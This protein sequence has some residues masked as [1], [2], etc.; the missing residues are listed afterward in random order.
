MST[1]H[2]IPP[3]PSSCSWLWHPLFRES[4]NWGTVQR[5]DHVEQKHTPVTH[6]WKFPHLREFSH[7]LLSSPPRKQLLLIRVLWWWINTVLLEHSTH[8]AMPQVLFASVSFYSVSC[9]GDS[10]MP[11]CLAAACFFL[12]L[13]RI[14]QNKFSTWC[15]SSHLVRNSQ[16]FPGWHTARKQYCNY[17]ASVN[18]WT[19]VC[20]SN[21]GVELL[22]HGKVVAFA[23][24]ET[25]A[26]PW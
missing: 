14:L 10:P 1:T 12:L 22:G 16:W 4:F 26:S 25:M 6:I 18:M 20:A 9:F 17:G 11:L 19:C 24:H 2:C 15:I 13:D 21:L 7:L 8:G 23:L 5:L 3:S